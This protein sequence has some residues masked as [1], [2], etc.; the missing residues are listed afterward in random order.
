MD[1]ASEMAMIRANVDVLSETLVFSNPEAEPLGQNT[2][3][4]EFHAKCKDARPRI[5][6]MIRETQDESLL[7]A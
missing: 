7:S 5:Q 3:I 1:A 2:L 4:Q 6:D